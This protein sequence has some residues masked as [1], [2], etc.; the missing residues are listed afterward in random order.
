MSDS[1]RKMMLEALTELYSADDY[2]TAVYHMPR[3]INDV[4]GEDF[5][6]YF[7]FLQRLFLTKGSF[8]FMSPGELQVA[9]THLTIT[10]KRYSYPINQLVGL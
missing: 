7:D 6:E 9:I 4:S 2:I 5:N 3:E 10:A 1:E 8:M